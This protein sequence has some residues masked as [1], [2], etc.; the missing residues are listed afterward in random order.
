MR[1]KPLARPS[2]FLLLTLCAGAIVMPGL[3]VTLPLLALLVGLAV[4]YLFAYRYVKY[5]QIQ[6]STPPLGRTDEVMSWTVHT[7]EDPKSTGGWLLVGASLKNRVPLVA[8]RASNLPVVLDK[9]GVYNVAQ[10]H[11]IGVGPLFLPLH[12]TRKVTSPLVAPLIVAPKL[13]PITPLLEAVKNVRM[14]HDGEV[15][16]GGDVPGGPKSIRPFERGD[17]MSTVHWPATART[18]TIHV[19]E[20]E[21][22]GGSNAVTVVVEHIDGSGRGEQIL[23]EATWLIHQLVN[24]GVRVDLAT[25]KIRTLITSAIRADEIL[26]SIEPGVFTGTTGL[27]DYPNLGTVRVVGAHWTVEG[28]PVWPAGLRPLGFRPELTP[29]MTPHLKPAVIPAP[30]SVPQPTSSGQRR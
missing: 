3:N 16:E 28:V 5:A 4:N 26:A 7:P 15:S 23:G 22:L 17:R 30:L 10:L 18:G 1:T 21:R 2:L 25:P 29:Q 24:S 20:L 6:L 11:L 8:G 19:K 14:L 27:R 9:R 13:C 12:A